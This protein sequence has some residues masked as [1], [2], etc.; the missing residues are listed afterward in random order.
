[1]ITAGWRLTPY[2]AYGW[3]LC[4]P[5]KRNAIRHG[6]TDLFDLLQ[7]KALRFADGSVCPF[8]PLCALADSLSAE[9]ASL[10]H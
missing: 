5:D 4:R 3:A 2:P 1:M 9:L 8:Y 7:D 6:Q 10:K